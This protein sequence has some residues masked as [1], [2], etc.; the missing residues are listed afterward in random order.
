MGGEEL[1]RLVGAEAL[2]CPAA[3]AQHDPLVVLEVEPSEDLEEASVC[4]EVADRRL[5]E[6]YPGVALAFPAEV[7]PRAEPC[8]EAALA[9]P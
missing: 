6:P 7:G 3:E 8:P 2:A 1:R 4:Q 9:L 5:A